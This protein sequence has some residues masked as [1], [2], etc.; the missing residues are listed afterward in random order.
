MREACHCTYSHSNWHVKGFDML[1]GGGAMTL[2]WSSF[3]MMASL[4]SKS[5]TGLFYIVKVIVILA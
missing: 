5:Q 1:E 3:P 2:L 4:S